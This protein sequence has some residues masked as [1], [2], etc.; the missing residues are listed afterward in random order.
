MSH[1]QRRQTELDDQLAQKYPRFF[2]QLG[3]E[4]GQRL[5]QQDHRRV[6]DQRTADRHALLLAAGE[7]VRMALGQMPQPELIQ[8]RLYPLGDFRRGGLTQL[9]RI[10]HVLKHRFVRPQGVGLKHQPRL[11]SSAG[12]SLRALPL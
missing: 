12:I 5:I 3:V 7:L 6:V 4:V 11:R 8:H 9:Q 2:A 1:H 10:S